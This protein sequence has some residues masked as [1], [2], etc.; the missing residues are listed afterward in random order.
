MKRLIIL[1]G[2]A[3][4]ATSCAVVQPQQQK[5]IVSFLDYRPYTEAGF[6][7]SPY[8]Y[9]GKYEAIGQLDIIVYPEQVTEGIYTTKK[10][11]PSTDLL[12]KAVKHSLGKGANGIANLKISRISNTSVSKYG[13]I[14][15]LSHYEVSGFLIRISDL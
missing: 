1:L 8:N 3:I 14:S 15:S 13:T 10:E 12:D 6:F 11:I 4:L 9:T 2:L 5:E 7:I